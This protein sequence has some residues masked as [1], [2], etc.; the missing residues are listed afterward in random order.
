MSLCVESTAQQQIPH[1]LHYEI[2]HEQYQKRGF[3]CNS[4]PFWNYSSTFISY[5]NSELN[6]KNQPEVG[7]TFAAF[8]LRRSCLQVGFI[9]RGEDICQRALSQQNWLED[10]L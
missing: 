4:S 7:Y 9:S 3:A 1:S 8:E 10:Q 2:F 5:K 6:R